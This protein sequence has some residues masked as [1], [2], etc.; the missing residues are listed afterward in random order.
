MKRLLTPA[1]CIKDK[2]ETTYFSLF[3]TLSNYFLYMCVWVWVRV[4]GSVSVSVFW[5]FGWNCKN[6]FSIQWNSFIFKMVLIAVWNHTLL[7][8]IARIGLL[9]TVRDKFGLR[10]AEAKSKTLLRS[11]YILISVLET[12]FKSRR[13]NRN[14]SFL[15]VL[16]AWVCNDSISKRIHFFLLVQLNVFLALELN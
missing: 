1:K 12:A 3:S 10:R 16:F 15:Q 11:L 6:W 14:E 4:C 9:F 13:K 8:F 7:V 2:F 5:K